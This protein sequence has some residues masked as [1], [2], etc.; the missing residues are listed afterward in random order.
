MVRQNVPA[1]VQMTRTETLNRAPMEQDA[2]DVKIFVRFD[3]S[4]SS[5]WR[6]EFEGREFEI[7]GLPM[8]KDGRRREMVLLGY[9]VE[10]KATLTLGGEN[11]TQEEP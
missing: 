7:L 5:D 8:D 11:G 2:A 10:S 6:V 9:F 1:H 3:P 4:I